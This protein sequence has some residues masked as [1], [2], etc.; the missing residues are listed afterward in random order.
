MFRLSDDQQ[1]VLSASDLT[2]YLA[3]RHLVEQKRGVALGERAKWHAP[4]D[5]HADLAR[6][7]GDAHE[8]AILRELASRLG[9]CVDLSAGPVHSR[10]GLQAQADRTAAAM[11]AGV[12]LIFQPQFFDGRWQGRLDFLRRVDIP[13]GLGAYGYEVVDTKLARQVKPYVVHQL[14]LYTRLLATVQGFAPPG[15]YVILGDGSEQLVEL[16]RYAAL[17]RYV[18]GQLERLVE[19]PARVTYP[20]PAAHCRLCDLD[21]ECR[22]RRRADDHLSLVAGARR[23]QRARLAELGITTVHELAAAPAGLPAGKLGEDRFDVL[24]H[25]AA[26]QVRTWEDGGRHHRHLAARYDRGYARLPRPDAGDVFFDLEGDP[27]VG[28][29]GGI[30]YLWGWCTADGAYDCL[31]AHDAESEKAALESFVDFVTARRRSHPGLRVFHYAPH[32]SSKLLS[33]AQ[34]YGTR[35]REVDV[36]Q[37]EGVL[38]DLYAIVRQAVQVG[39][40]SYGLKRLERHTGFVRRETTVREGG[41][42]IVAYERW[43]ETGDGSLLA[44]IR[45]YNRE[46]CLSTLVLRDWLL[47]P[48]KAEAARELGVD[49]AGLAPEEEKS[50]AP[51]DWAVELQAIADRLMDG[52]PADSAGDDAA[53]A[54]RRLLAQLLLFH[55]REAKPAWWRFFAL[56]EM[57][58]ERLIDERDAIGGLHLDPADRPVRANARSTDWTLRFPPQEVKIDGDQYHDPATGRSLNVQALEDDRVVIR[59]STADGKP[60][61][62]ALIGSGAIPAK[63]MREALQALG[64]GLLDGELHPPARSIL[65]RL[66]PRLAGGRPFLQVGDPGLGEMAT[67]GLELQGGHLAVQGPPG[68]GKTWRGARMIVAALAAGRRVAVTAQSHAAIQNLLAAV[69]EAAHEAGLRFRGIYKGAGYGSVR[70]LIEV[71]DDNAAT[72][73]DGFDLVAG[74]AWLLTREGHRG[75]YGLVFVDEAGQYSL[76]NALA[77]SL[78]ADGIIL[79]GDPQQL[80]QVTQA[81]HPDG[82]GAS[83]LEHLLNGL[84]T[85]PADRG[86]FLTATWRM[87]PEITAFVSERSYGRRLRSRDACSERRVT[88]SGSLDGAGLRA[89]AVEHEGRSQSSP[90][91]AAAIAAACRELLA[92]GTVTDDEGVARALRPDDLMVVAP[93]NL[94]V[95]CIRDAVP[96]RVRVG[97]VD[98]FQGQEAPVVFYAMTCSSGEDVPRGL[99]F[100]FN[101]NRLNVAVSRAQCIAVLVHSPRLLEANCPTLA[102]MELVDGA[103]R[104]VELA[105]EA[106]ARLTRG[107][108]AR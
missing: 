79:L 80:P 78:C 8:R 21:L 24:R 108:T 94:A 53:M 62:T 28:A 81:S 99:D 95:R 11:R 31:W 105:S 23:E 96:P 14:S 86:Y 84:S 30:E 18:T 12:P 72:E 61:A 40:E 100:L 52:L 27:Y 89:L 90:E 15:A 93:Y 1:L 59:R 7:H 38:V 43:L 77:V 36:L 29:D 75:R 6:T 4:A 47:D 45:A 49:F 106:N 17:H 51:P 68:T 16:G 35:E 87:A 48:M 10:E 60:T 41:G 71:T 85:I 13:S 74:T 102:A 97:T 46:D 54:E 92:G 73:A 2:A 9:D 82:A 34:R 20:E 39:E 66:A 83:V 55:H 67:A 101:R 70:G 103:C 63:A 42:S 64:S 91:E 56:Q 76:A 19:E 25:Q 98:R 50:Y 69:E 37:A 22:T 88:A 5:P 58:S 26:L 33:L 104:F 44:A 107:A 57:S 32:E 65:R 3:C